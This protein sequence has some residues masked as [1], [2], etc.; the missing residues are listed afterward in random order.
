M[1]GWKL[2]LRLVSTWRVGE[3][4][5]GNRAAANQTPEKEGWMEGRKKEKEKQGKKERKSERKKK[6]TKGNK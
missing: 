4:G 3:G 1:P 5:G 6:Q 2:L